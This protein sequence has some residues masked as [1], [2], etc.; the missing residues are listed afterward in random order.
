MSGVEIMKEETV[1][2]RSQVRSE[3]RSA[4]LLDLVHQCCVESA[5]VNHSTKVP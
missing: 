1:D 4:L 3:D 2:V 5:C